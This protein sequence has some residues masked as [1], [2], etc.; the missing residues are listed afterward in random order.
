[1]W[2][3]ILASKPGQQQAGLGRAGMAR[4]AACWQGKAGQG[5]A[6]PQG[7]IQNSRFKLPPCFF[8]LSSFRFRC[9][10]SHATLACYGS[11]SSSSSSSSRGPAALP[12]AFQ[13]K[14]CQPRGGNNSVEQHSWFMSSGWP[15]RRCAN[16]SGT[17]FRLVG[18]GFRDEL[19]A[20]P[21]QRCCLNVFPDS[22]APHRPTPPEAAPCRP[23]PPHATGRRRQVE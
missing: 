3:Q 12:L 19:M 7:R 22:A 21:V 8:I 2:G 20:L 11:S 17:S 18:E 6:A 13:S 16:W 10:P 14:R 15:S 9:F 4:L 5:T 1:M 23:T